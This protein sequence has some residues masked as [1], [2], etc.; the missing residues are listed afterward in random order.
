MTSRPCPRDPSRIDSN[1]RAFAGSQRWIQYYVNE[2]TEDLNNVIIETEKSLPDS[3]TFQWVSPLRSNHYTE[4]RDEEFL[5]R[6]ELSQFASELRCWW[7]PNG[8]CWDALAIV[9]HDAKLGA[10]LLEAKSYPREFFGDGCGAGERSRI[11]IDDALNATKARFG[12]DPKAD[13]AGRLY[14]YANRLAHLHL[15]RTRL[16]VPTWLVNVCFVEDPHSPTSLPEWRN[17]LL[18][19]HEKLGLDSDPPFVSTVFLP[20][21]EYQT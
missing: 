15:L 12:A 17:E 2:R 4:Y 10:L 14:Q 9:R 11:R 5:A 21:A 13:W 19:L 8:P 1:G 20:A 16:G 3:S 7:P 6:L 18:G